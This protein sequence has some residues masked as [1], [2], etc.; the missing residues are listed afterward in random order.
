MLRCVLSAF[1]QRIHHINNAFLH[2][3][4][5]QNALGRLA[6]RSWGMPTHGQ[7]SAGRN[8]STP[9]HHQRVPSGDLEMSARQSTSSIGTEAGAASDG[10]GPDVTGDPSRPQPSSISSTGSLGAAA[11]DANSIASGHSQPA[12]HA[13]TAQTGVAGAAPGD[14]LCSIATQAGSAAH[15]FTS[16]HSMMTTHGD[17]SDG[18]VSLIPVPPAAAAA[19]SDRAALAGLSTSP[20]AGT[21]SAV[22]LLSAY[23]S[24]DAGGDATS[25]STLPL[26]SEAGFDERLLDVQGLTEEQEAEAARRDGSSDGP[27]EAS[28]DALQ[29]KGRISS[30]HGSYT[31]LVSNTSE[32]SG[33]L[34]NPAAARIP[35]PAHTRMSH[36]QRSSS[37][38]SFQQQLQ[39]QLLQDLEESQE[40]GCSISTGLPVPFSTRRRPDN[41]DMCSY[42]TQAGSSVHSLSSVISH[43]EGTQSRGQQWSSDGNALLQTTGSNRSFSS[44]QRQHSTSRSRWSSVETAG[45]LTAASPANFAG[46]SGA[47]SPVTEPD[48]GPDSPTAGQGPG[49][50]PPHELQRKSSLKG[51]LRAVTRWGSGISQRL[52]RSGSIGSHQQHR[53]KDAQQQ[54]QQQQQQQGGVGAA[55]KA[56]HSA[57]SGQELVNLRRPV[58]Q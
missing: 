24:S 6:P 23:R 7:H 43:M 10:P 36:S 9:Q 27:L 4:T 8:G 16:L 44:L 52:Q 40:E 50:E 48:S 17:V 21:S 15:S 56:G 54:Q 57:G 1:I 51:A 14:D 2:D 13:S 26:I 18:G 11:N 46:V 47:A 41:D 37:R 39:Q 32:L 30:S 38:H 49:D 45:G 42:A 31:S 28:S 25:V 58:T 22:S 12:R 20:T 33:S 29:P 3:P 55:I 35:S 53:K 5:L 19:A 34:L